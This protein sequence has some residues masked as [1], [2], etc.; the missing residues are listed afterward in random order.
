MN[1]PRASDDH[2]PLYIATSLGHLDCCKVLIENGA[3]MK[4]RIKSTT[5]G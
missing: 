4:T 2:T 3:D 5:E 1:Q